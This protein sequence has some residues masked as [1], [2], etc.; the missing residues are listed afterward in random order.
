MVRPL[1]WYKSLSE[2]KCRL[3]EGYFLL[4]GKKAIDQVFDKA[5]EAIED[6]LVTSELQDSVVKYQRPVRVLTQ[7]QLHLISSVKTPQGL[8]ALVKIP[9]DSFTDVLPHS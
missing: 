4:E 6:I 5:P 8:A 9:I 3:D 1:K 7:S 2:S